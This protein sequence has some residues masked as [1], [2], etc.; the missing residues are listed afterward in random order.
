MFLSTHLFNLFSKCLD[1][2]VKLKP[3]ARKLLENVLTCYKKRALEPF[4]ISENLLERTVTGQDTR[5]ELGLWNVL[6]LF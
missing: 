4:E 6:L 1:S 3:D 2:V 5:L